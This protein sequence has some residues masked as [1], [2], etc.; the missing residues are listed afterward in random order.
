MPTQT[1]MVAMRDG[2]RLATDVHLPEGP[3]PFPAVLE[4]TPYGRDQTSR[5]ELSAADPVPQRRGAVAEQLAARGL[6]RRLPGLPRPLRLGG[7][8]REVPLG[9]GGRVRH[10]RLAA[11]A[12]VV[13][14]A[15][16]APWG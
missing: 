13:R 4:R 10:L 9:R 15:H 1:V 3:G 7:A 6:R 14:R 8:V 16:P 12:A 11:A 2:V 5:S